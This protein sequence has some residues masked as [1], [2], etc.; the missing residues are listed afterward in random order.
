MLPFT[1]TAFLDISAPA[2]AIAAGLAQLAS[3]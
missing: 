1:D 2:L 3:P